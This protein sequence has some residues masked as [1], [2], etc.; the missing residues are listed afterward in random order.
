[1]GTG[2]AT[3]LTLLPAEERDCDWKKIRR[4]AGYSA[5]RSR[6]V[7]RSLCCH[8]QADSV[9]AQTCRRL[10][11]VLVGLVVLGSGVG[12]QRIILLDALLLF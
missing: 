12:G 6:S 4:Y 8:R 3:S 5:D 9:A 11:L 10:G 1:M 7:Q 2:L